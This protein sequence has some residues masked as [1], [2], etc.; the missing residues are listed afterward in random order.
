MLVGVATACGF[1]A[2]YNI[3]KLPPSIP[4]LRSE[5]TTT[6][7][8][9]AALVSSYSLVA[10]TCALLMGGIVAR[11]GI[12]RTVA[13]GLMLLIA[14]GALGATTDRF[15][16][17]LIAR[18]LEGLGYLAIAITMPAF[19][20][21]VCSTANRPIAMGVWGTFVPG[22][23]T[24]CMLVTPILSPWGGWRALWWAGVAST[25]VL[26]VV[27]SLVIRPVA[28]EQQSMEVTP[29][30]ALITVLHRVP[31]LLAL[32]F[33]VYS[34]TF[35][36][37]STFLP[38]YWSETL[39]MSVASASQWTAQVIS[40]NILGNL[41]GGWLNKRGLPVRRLLG[42]GVIVA[43]VFAAIAYMPIFAFGLQLTG[44]CLF[45]FI[46]GITPSTLFATTPRITDSP[47][48]NSLVLGML[49]QGVGTGQVVGPLLAGALADLTGSWSLFP[50]YFV[51]C[52]CLAAVLLSLLPARVG[53]ES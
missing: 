46:C 37:L 16:T 40:V 30:P 35:T 27:A 21:R 28:L 31:V 22:G 24:L 19:I 51:L 20:S 11:L 10:M 6:L 36:G 52:A 3:G 34:M 49:L 32:Y 14:G 41:F 9:V 12:W 43:S 42:T 5:F 2:A 29:R 8:W 13:G 1:A 17:L 15:D 53:N 39:G 25:L 44:A 48:Q 26:L 7:T 47:A 4:E 38:T 45:S 50:M 33:A 18:V 23:I